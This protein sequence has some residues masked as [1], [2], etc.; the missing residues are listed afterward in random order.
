MTDQTPP[1]RLRELVEQWRK[2]AVEADEMSNARIA[3]QREK[4]A[5]IH[6]AFARCYR[7]CAFEL[8]ALLSPGVGAVPEPGWREIAS[9]P[10]DRPILLFAPHQGRVVGYYHHAAQ[11][12]AWE[13]LPGWHTIKPS[14]W[15][16]L[17]E[18][19]PLGAVPEPQ[20]DDKA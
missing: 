11:N 2:T 17:P 18:I 19:P 20:K 16:P 8:S 7:Q 14:H 1:E 9:A 3:Q 6:D 13:S 12:S 15:M 5:A 4:A 10:K